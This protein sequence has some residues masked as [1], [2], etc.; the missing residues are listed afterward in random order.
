MSRKIKP[1]A[2][3]A[4][5]I[6]RAG[7]MVAV[8]NDYCLGGKPYTFWL[9]IKQKRAVKGEGLTDAIALNK[10]REQIKLPQITPLPNQLGPVYDEQ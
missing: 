5:D 3:V 6:R 9:F 1:N 10:V 4:D 2:A 8:H 7:W